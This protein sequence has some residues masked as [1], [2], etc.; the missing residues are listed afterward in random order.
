MQYLHKREHLDSGDIVVVNCSH[1]CNVQLM[2]DTNYSNYK[3]GRGFKYYGGFYKML[4]ARISAPYTGNWNIV[5]DLGGGSANFRYSIN[6]IK[7]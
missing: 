6:I 3:S 7:Q 1:Q 2:D 4:P 5:I